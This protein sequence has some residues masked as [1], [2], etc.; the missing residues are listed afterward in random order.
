M[1]DAA[2][3]KATYA[4]LQAVPPN[5]VAELIDGALVTHPRPAPRH[6]TASNSLSGEIGPPFQKGRGGPGGWI[7]MDEAEL[8][9]EP[10]VVV[11]AIAGWRR[12]HLSALPETPWIET[13][14]DWVCEVLSP[15][16]ASY[17]RGPKRRIYRDAGVNFLWLLDVEATQLEA[18]AL[19]ANQWLLMGTAGRGEEISLPPFDA[20][21]FSFDILFPFDPPAEDADGPSR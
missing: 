11:P 5:R 13:A 9:L 20:I 19:T 15:S 21:S 16:T 1:G 8:H 18:F 7:F 10:D 4:D 12:E 14:P 6:A 17:D 3:Q 2:H